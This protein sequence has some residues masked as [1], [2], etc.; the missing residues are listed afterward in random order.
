MIHIH[1]SKYDIDFD[2]MSFLGPCFKFPEHK[3]HWTKQG[4][5]ASEILK[6][7]ESGKDVHVI[8]LSGYVFW[9]I[10][11]Q[12]LTRKTLHRNDLKI[13]YHRSEDVINISGIGPNLELSAEL[14]SHWDGGGHH[15]ANI[16]SM[17]GFYKGDQVNKYTFDD[18]VSLNKNCA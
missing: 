7:H 14:N 3:V 11:E 15:I 8:T 5:I 13:H 9:S 10:I 17:L 1:T 2:K 12:G 4:S 18:F 6:L 16:R